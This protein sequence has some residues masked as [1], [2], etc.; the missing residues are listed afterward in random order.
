MNEVSKPSMDAIREIQSSGVHQDTVDIS[1][2]AAAW[3]CPQGGT[4]TMVSGACRCIKIIGGQRKDLG[5]CT[6]TNN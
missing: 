6:W 1:E 2:P 4:P 5:P 3:T